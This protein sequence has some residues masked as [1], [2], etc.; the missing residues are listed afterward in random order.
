M[1]IQ[2]CLRFGSQDERVAVF[3]EIKPHLLTLSTNVYALHL[4][5]ACLSL[6]SQTERAVAFKKLKSHLLTLSVDI[7]TVDIV[8]TLL[9][10]GVD[11]ILSHRS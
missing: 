10:T 5:K 9:D 8:D 6:C 7:D 3:K 1:F 2:D 4:V 11:Y